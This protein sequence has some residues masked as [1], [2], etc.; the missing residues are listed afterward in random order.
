MSHVHISKILA[1]IDC[2]EARVIEQR[3]NSVIRA[4]LKW[5]TLPD[6]TTHFWVYNGKFVTS[7]I[8]Q[9]STT[10]VYPNFRK[11]AREF[12]LKFHP[13]KFKG[14]RTAEITNALGM[15]NYDPPVPAINTLLD[16]LA[17]P[18]NAR[19]SRF[20]GDCNLYNIQFCDNLRDMYGFCE[21]RTV[22]LTFFLIPLINR[23]TSDE[24]TRHL[25]T[26][27]KHGEPA[28]ITIADNIFKDFKPAH[29]PKLKW[30]ARATKV[31][32]VSTAIT[33]VSRL[34]YAIHRTVPVT[35][36]WVVFVNNTLRETS[37]AARAGQGADLGGDLGGGDQ[38]PT[39]PVSSVDTP[40][41]KEP[42]YKQ[43]R[44]AKIDTNQLPTPTEV[45]VP[46]VTKPAIPQKRSVVVTTSTTK[47]VRRRAS[48]VVTKRVTRSMAAPRRSKRLR[49]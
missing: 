44:P 12:N 15:I 10:E 23:L 27:Y 34:I 39:S 37:D 2:E 40:R 29:C 22:G 4:D 36:N 1:C 17:M 25:T 24:F 6:N 45:V 26:I 28:I 38:T 33:C 32:S 14:E 31:R 13:D 11:F 18:I 16:I 20:I 5:V 48:P 49:R 35:D 41:A 47:R 19:S 43:K 8:S 46:L 30:M 3:F 42:S 21:K 9:L 7:S